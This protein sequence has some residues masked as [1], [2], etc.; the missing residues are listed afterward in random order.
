MWAWCGGVGVACL[1]R[2]GRVCM[3]RG[4][5]KNVMW[6]AVGGS[7][8]LVCAQAAHHTPAACLREGGLFLDPDDD[9]LTEARPLE[10]IFKGWMGGRV[11]G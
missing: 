1:R 4:W 7:L 9:Q 6:A 11:M 3:G 10:V 2:C 5:R 8:S